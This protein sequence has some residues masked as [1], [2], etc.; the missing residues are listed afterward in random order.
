MSSQ[1]SPKSRK[2]GKVPNFADL[3]FHRKLVSRVDAGHIVAGACPLCSS[4]TD[5]RA[6]ARATVVFFHGQTHMV[7]LT[8][9]GFE[10]LKFRR[11]TY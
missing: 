2:R 1:V 6:R 11:L 7:V 9:F 5:V 8:Q 3:R 4:C 10:P